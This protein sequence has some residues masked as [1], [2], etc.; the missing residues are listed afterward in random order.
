MLQLYICAYVYVLT[1]FQYKDTVGCFHLYCTRL[2]SYIYEYVGI[3]SIPLIV[4]T[5]NFV[6]K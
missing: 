2:L 4:K 5:C 1:V 3:K 6:L